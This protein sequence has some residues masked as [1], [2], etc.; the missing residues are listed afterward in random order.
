MNDTDV[1]RGG[2]TFI[3]SLR[4]S[5]PLSQDPANPYRRSIPRSLLSR[6]TQQTNTRIETNCRSDNRGSRSCCRTQQTPTEIETARG[7]E[8]IE[9][10]G[11]E[12]FVA[13]SQAFRKCLMGDTDFRCDLFEVRLSWH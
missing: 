13:P 2:E 8:S 7:L 11:D 1:E 4:Y 10:G 9:Y 5:Y 3:V 12:C 6:R